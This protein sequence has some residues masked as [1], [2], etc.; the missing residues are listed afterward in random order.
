MTPLKGLLILAVLA[1]SV[2]SFGQSYVVTPN[3]LRDSSDIEKPYLVILC[4]GKTAKE[5]FDNA[6]KYIQQTYKNP[7]EVIK[8]QIEAEYLSFDTY[9]SECIS[10]KRGA[11]NPKFNATYRTEL[12][13]K[14]GKVKYEISNLEMESD[15]NRLLFTGN[16]VSMG[17]YDQK[18]GLR[19]E[20][21][22]IVIENYFNGH[23]LIISNFLNGN[24][25]IDEW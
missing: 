17:I 15:G 18:G 1:V 8:G 10:F 9:C 12:S 16:F 4:E 19:Q 25:V 11:L 20:H 7:Q 23:I 24:K 6:I 3:G 22:K 21:G 5:L 13:F 2:L 14:D